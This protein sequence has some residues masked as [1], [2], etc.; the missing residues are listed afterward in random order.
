M[1]MKM[2]G[3][4]MRMNGWSDED[5]HGEADTTGGGID[6]SGSSAITSRSSKLPS[7]GTEA[8][9]ST[10]PPPNDL[11]P[12]A[13]FDKDADVQPE[14]ALINSTLPPPVPPLLQILF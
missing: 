6:G 3:W 1:K 9:V 5:E 4:T 14:A 7:R 10:I 11:P 2:A 8:N 12:R 13:V